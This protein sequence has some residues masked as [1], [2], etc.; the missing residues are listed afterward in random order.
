[1]RYVIGRTAP[2]LG[3]L[4]SFFDDF[5]SD[6]ST[7]KYPPVDIYE[8]ADAYTIE[9]EVAGYSDD[10]IKITVKDGVITIASDPSWKERLRK[11]MEARKLIASEISLPEFS[12]SFSLPEDSDQAGITADSGNGIL[13]ITIP[14]VRKAEPGRIEVKIGK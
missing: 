8:T 4:D 6:V 1:M 5:F 13:T 12:R 11:R 14:R 3:G 2:V 10:D 9:L 7:R